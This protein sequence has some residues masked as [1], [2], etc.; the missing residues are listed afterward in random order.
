MGQPLQDHAHLFP[1]S[2]PPPPTQAAFLLYTTHAHNTV[3]TGRPLHPGFQGTRSCLKHPG[4]CFLPLTELGSEGTIQTCEVGTQETGQREERT[5]DVVPG[6][7]CLSLTGHVT[8]GKSLSSLAQCH[9]LGC[10]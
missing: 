10:V 3:D 1:P 5:R 9:V 7:S 6:S 8:L 2:G 4:L